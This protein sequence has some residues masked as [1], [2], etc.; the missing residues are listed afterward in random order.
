[1]LRAKGY[2]GPIDV[3]PHGIDLEAYAEPTPDRRAAA[4]ARFGARGIVIGYA[5]RLLPMKGVDV[6]LTAAAGLVSK[7]VSHEFSVVVLGE[8][9]DQERLRALA[10]SLGIADRVRFVA[11]VPHEAIPTALEAFD[12]M[13]VPSLSTPKWKEQFGRV[14]LEGMAAGAAVVVSSSG[15]LPYVVGDAGIV[16]PEGDAVALTEALSGLVESHAERSEWGAR[17]RA[18]A[19]TTFTWSAIASTLAARYRAMLATDRGGD[20]K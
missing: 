5:G 1:V 8:G 14:A 15:G 18:R 19:R 10:E 20:A 17:G 9:P 4:R 11:G 6:L 7:G 13:V 2:R 3:V 16:T 12:V